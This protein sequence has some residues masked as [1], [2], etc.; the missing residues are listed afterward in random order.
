MLDTHNH[1]LLTGSCLSSHGTASSTMHRLD[2]LG[3]KVCAGRAGRPSNPAIVLELPET[4]RVCTSV[5]SR[6][7][8]SEESYDDSTTRGF[9]TCISLHKHTKSPRRIHASV[10]NRT[11]IIGT[12]APVPRKLCSEGSPSVARRG[13]SCG[14][15][16]SLESD[17]S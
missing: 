11:Q 1:A 15:L 12:V 17:L 6:R 5:S 4:S 13:S 10:S 14:T 2:V 9:P 7:R 3:R 8:K 16:S